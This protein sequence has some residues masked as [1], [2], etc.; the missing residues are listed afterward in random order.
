MNLRARLI[1]AVVVTLSLGGCS[2]TEPAG[3][4]VSDQQRDAMTTSG[5]EGPG[6]LHGDAPA[7]P[8]DCR[9]DRFEFATTWRQL[10]GGMHHVLGDGMADRLEDFNGSDVGRPNMPD[11]RFDGAALSQNRVFAVI[12]QGGIVLVTEVW[13]FQ[14]NGSHW[15]GQPRWSGH[16]EMTF[17][18]IL[19]VACRQFVPRRHSKPPARPLDCTFNRNG[20]V[21]IEYDL[22]GHRRN[23][24]VR[25]TSQKDW[26]FKREAIRNFDAQQPATTAEQAELLETLKAA[27]ASMG[28]DDDCRY[29]ADVFLM[30]L[31][32]AS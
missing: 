19:A 18:Q 31:N 24:E 7:D 25:P 30:A 6:L 16:P 8:V 20:L 14:R 1:A 28:W 3:L 5:K 21:T 32:A 22:A 26:N 4:L 10:P 2:K 13:A 29:E 23:F 15:D 9:S 12:E 17:Q 27:R 11:R